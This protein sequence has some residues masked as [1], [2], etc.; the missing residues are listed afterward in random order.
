MSD[1]MSDF[2]NILSKCGFFSNVDP[3]I[4][5]ISNFATLIRKIRYKSYTYYKCV[6]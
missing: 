2:L 4:D 5:I 3:K 6:L 1:K